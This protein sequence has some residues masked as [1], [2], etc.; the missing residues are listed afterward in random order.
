[1]VPKEGGHKSQSHTGTDNEKKMEL[2]WAHPEKTTRKYHKA[3][4]ELKSTSRPQSLH[5]PPAARPAEQH[6]ASTPPPPPSRLDPPVTGVTA[7]PL[8][9]METKK[10]PAAVQPQGRRKSSGAQSQQQLRSPVVKRPVSAPVTLQGWLHKQGSEGL[11]LWKKRW[12][13]LS[14]Y[15]LFYYK[16]PEE[17]KLLGSILLPSYK[18]SPCSAED[19][20][21]RKFAFKAE[22]TNMRTYYFA[23]DSRE[24]MVQW[25]NALSL[26]SILQ[27]SGSWDEHRSGRPSVSSIS[28]L[29]NQSADDSDSGF[30]GYRSR[31]GMS[32]AA[33][34]RHK[35]NDDQNKS[36]LNTSHDSALSN[37][38]SNQKNNPQQQAEGGYHQPLY[39]NAPPKPRRLTNELDDYGTPTPDLTP[40]RRLDDALSGKASNP[41]EDKLK[42]VNYEPRI[43]QPQEPM[44]SVIRNDRGGI[45]ARYHY[46]MPAE[47]H[48]QRMHGA[49]A[50]QPQMMQ[51][52]GNIAQVVPN[53]E[54]RTPDTYGRS[55][56][57]TPAPVVPG[58]PLVC[59]PGVVKSGGDY[60]DVYNTAE[61]SRHG[62]GEVTYAPMYRRSSSSQVAYIKGAGPTLSV[63]QQPQNYVVGSGGH[64][65]NHAV[66][67][68]GGQFIHAGQQQQQIYAPYRYA[69]NMPS[70]TPQQQSVPVPHPHQHQHQHQHQ[71]HPQHQ[72]Q[73]Q[74]VPQSR[75]HNPRSS[76]HPP[77]PHSAD[78][79]E[80]DSRRYYQQQ[81]YQQ[82]S[83]PHPHREQIS[84]DHSLH[85]MSDKT[86]VDQQGKVV[87]LPRPKSSLDVMPSSDPLQTDSYYYSE[88]SYA[89]K[90]RQSASY[91]QQAPLPVHH[92]NH[93]SSSR[94]TTPSIRLSTPST[95][96]AMMTDGVPAQQGGGIAQVGGVSS[97]GSVNSETPGVVL[98]H[99]KRTDMLPTD[100]RSPSRQQYQ[101]QQQRRWSEY[102]DIRT[103]GQFIRSASARL[104]R[105]RYQDEE[106]EESQGDET[107]QRSASDLREGERKIQQREESM[108]RLLEWKQRMLQSP[109]TRKPSGSSTRG[110]AQNE[111]SKYYKQQ[112]LRE[113]ATQEAR[114]RDESRGS[115]R[116][117]L[118]EDSHT[119][120]GP[121]RASMR[122]RSQDG[123]RSSTSISRY[124]S[125]SSD[126]EASGS[127]SVIGRDPLPPRAVSAISIQQQ[128]KN[129]QP[130]AITLTS[131]DKT[132]ASLIPADQSSGTTK[133][134]APA[135]VANHT[136]PPGA[137][138]HGDPTP[139][140]RGE[141]AEGQGKRGRGS[142]GPNSPWGLNVS[143]GE[144]LGRT[145]EE[146]VLLLIQLRRQ[147]AGVCKA[148]ETCHMEI[149]AQ[150]RLA[151]LETPKRL[152]HLKKLEELKK[153]L[154]EL[155]KQYEKGKPLVNLVDNM[156]KLGSLYRGSSTQLQAGLA[157]PG[158]GP[159]VRDR[160]EFNQKVQEQRLLAEE[161]KDWE[162]LS[163]DHG[164]L[165]AKVQE[166][167]RLDRLLQEESG[168]LQSLQQDKE[169]LEKALGGLKHKLQ[170]A[171]TNP[172]EAERYRK[173]QRLLER[174]L[175]RV[176]MLLAH[177]SKKLEETVAENARLEQE[178]VVLRQKLQASRRGSQPLQ[179]AP[180]SM[181]PDGS[182]SGTTAALEAELRRVQQL[183]GD[184][185]RQRQELSVQVRQLTEKSHSLVQQIRPGP[186]G[187][188]G[189]GPIPGRKRHHSTWLET[190]LD[191]LVT[192]D[193]G[194]DSP[195]SPQ[196][197]TSPPGSKNTPQDTLS[198]S[199]LYVNTETTTKRRE[200]SYEGST[201]DGDDAI[202][203]PL[204]APP[205]MPPD[206][207]PPPPPPP[208][209]SEE[210][211][212]NGGMSPNQQ[213]CSQ[214]D[215][216]EA[217]DRMKR[218]YGI[219][220]REKQQ[221]IKTVRIV[222]RE[223]ER[224]QRDRDRSG[225]IGIPLTNGTGT[226][227][228]RVTIMDENEQ[229]ALHQAEQ[230][231]QL[232][233]VLEEEPPE[234]L[235]LFEGDPMALEDDPVLSQFQRSMS[236]PR[237][238]G[239]R[240]RLGFNQ[241]GGVIP[242][243]PPVR[244]PSPRSDSVTALR[245]LMINRHRVRFESCSGGSSSAESTNSQRTNSPSMPRPLT[246]HEQLFGGAQYCVMSPGSS[247]ASPQLSPVFKSEA[248]RAIV[249][250]MSTMR[251]AG[252]QPR[253]RVVPKEKRRH[254]TVSS[255]RPLLD[256]ESTLPRMQ[257]SARSRDDLDMERALRP[258]LNAPDVVRSTM[259]HKDF[260]YNEDTI[261]SILGTPNK[262]VI[263]ERYIPEQAPELT[264]EEQL[265]RSKKAD[266]IRKM[267]SET[268]ALSTSDGKEPVEEEQT[269]TLKK[270]VLAEKKQR[271]HLLQLNQILAK[272][273]MEKSKIVAVKALATLPLKTEPSFDEDDL[274]PIQPLPL[275]QQRE[276]YFS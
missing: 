270:K 33:T 62:M 107:R 28:S 27:E 161:R 69:S 80:Y 118:P 66:P 4:I 29:L 241:Q 237:G 265:H 189:A 81:A 209:P 235:H 170:V 169:L 105:Q 156:V 64:A 190:D 200:P 75:Q 152:E 201:I 215:I 114:S 177:N 149:E 72:H 70:Q 179:R 45:D 168:T 26:A 83:L 248:A 274:S 272:Q 7:S 232:G 259:S 181:M 133:S 153:H 250:E 89:Q 239:K 199:P 142:G 214:M 20:V 50:Q 203:P 223:S 158:E 230:K 53:T 99:S 97:G 131:E 144:L 256:M 205:E 85:N 127:G 244:V 90:M 172:A 128:L 198:R 18:I 197:Q 54:R 108:K 218:F 228:K 150:A 2:D 86:Y 143:A 6:A 192:L 124:N 164:Q 109:L 35:S 10:G 100:T 94:A 141:P 13:V 71:Q 38:W 40:E 30:H 204:P 234:T 65:D 252:D 59:V 84:R 188:A 178:L 236:L 146:L 157:G 243:P 36:Q 186:T 227:N 49:P 258:R 159:S 77:R 255:S 145:H 48:Q 9:S 1:M 233:R 46:H 17:E 231:Q 251:D 88:E 240:E 261:D 31:P 19:R 247:D 202:P 55:N 266:A 74:S 273:V 229:G 129:S 110:T 263:P 245:N 21:Y 180:V 3:G 68:A 58:K 139:K 25:M 52:S 219:I 220:P 103:N 176:R 249:M 264:A 121:G 32:G 208:P 120:P 63:H 217:D 115:R 16:G 51:A 194:L 12:F 191:S 155:E 134:S 95:M 92:R 182:C 269:S 242:P 132:T 44:G 78:F 210:A 5:G 267:L 60:E 226:G 212:M 224:R 130:P 116:K 11:M 15:C 154:L 39:A 135:P 24:L 246:A 207:P 56:S 196:H 185:Q 112:V 195:A 140:E 126:D 125:F 122:S 271:E 238:F 162:R 76:R 148:M 111:L 160:L 113:L 193:H 23:A 171:R 61:A 82:H 225:N 262:I 123:R 106:N 183:V 253:K 43:A 136:G 137:P 174:E 22:H 42:H 257:G 147:S 268:T 8:V 138:P 98:R 163:P 37:G 211:M 276:N 260:K 167:Y 93:S 222:K 165:Q 14:E 173:Q 216:S 151:E 101:H 79:L 87:R 166:L 73:H 175:S 184:L 254:Y 117:L 47:Q 206:Y 102:T 275:F 119:I 34:P 91:V 104:P 96:S 221:E 213:Y 41:Q 187:V 57:T 67:Q